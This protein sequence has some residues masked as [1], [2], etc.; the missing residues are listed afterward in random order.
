MYC[1]VICL[2][3]RQNSKSD[4]VNSLSM[5]VT[6]LIHPVTPMANIL[7]NINISGTR[8]LHHTAYPNNEMAIIIKLKL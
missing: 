4:I 2:F 6:I 7:R 5:T 1:E 8:F 3:E